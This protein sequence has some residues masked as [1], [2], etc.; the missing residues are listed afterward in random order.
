M[1]TLLIILALMFSSLSIAQEDTET[2]TET[3]SPAKKAEQIHNLQYG[4]QL[5]SLKTHHENYLKNYGIPARLEVSSYDINDDQH[6]RVRAI[7]E[8]LVLINRLQGCLK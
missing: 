4:F 2:E 1:K 6:L 8:D 3:I 5:Q 7:M